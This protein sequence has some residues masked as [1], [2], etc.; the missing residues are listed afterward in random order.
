VTF[1][2]KFLHPV[3]QG[4]PDDTQAI[5][6]SAL[7]TEESRKFTFGECLLIRTPHQVRMILNQKVGRQVT[8]SMILKYEAILL[9]KDDLNLTTDEVLNPAIFLAEKEGRASKYKCLDMSKY[10]IKVWPDLGENFP[11]HVLFPYEWMLSVN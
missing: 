1:L 6:A 11:D 5:V 4:W 7:L 10:Q 9:E 3:T 8:D 2:T